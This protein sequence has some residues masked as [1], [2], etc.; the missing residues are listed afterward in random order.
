[1]NSIQTQAEN[2]ADM[3]GMKIAYLAYQEL[4]KKQGAEPML[5]K[6]NYSPSQLFWISAGNLMCTKEW[7]EIWDSIF[8]KNSAQSPSEFRVVGPLSNMPEFAE[9]FNCPVNSKMNPTKKCSVW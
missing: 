4:V 7:P 5:P 9:D 2:I 8:T 3:G 1:M 6:L